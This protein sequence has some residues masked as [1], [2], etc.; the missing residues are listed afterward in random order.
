MMEHIKRLF[1]GLLVFVVGFALVYGLMWLIFEQ[2]MYLVWG[3]II[4]SFLAFAYLTG[5][6]LEED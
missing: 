1:R 2:P 4:G 6:T 3:F 5:L